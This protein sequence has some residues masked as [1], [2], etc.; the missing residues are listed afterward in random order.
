MSAQSLSFTKVSQLPATTQISDSDVI[1]V[2]HNGV[3]SKMLYSDFKNLIQSDIDAEVDAL[4]TRVSTLETTCSS[5]ATRVST[6]EATVNNII[7]ASFNLIGIDAP[8]KKN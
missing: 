4:T 5:L 1:I 3:T 7:T 8:S 6:L 2:N